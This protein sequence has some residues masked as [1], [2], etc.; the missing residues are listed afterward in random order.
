[1]FKIIQEFPNYEINEEGIIR[2]IKTG[3]IR[4]TVIW[5]NKKSG[6]KTKQ[7]ILGKDKK[8]YTRKIHRLLA[9]TFI[10]N[11]DNL[12]EVDHI[13]RNQFKRIIN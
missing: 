6:H 2:Y 11:P 3:R 9:I 1:M 13:D 5:T 4:K 10:P 7:I 12:N 8:R